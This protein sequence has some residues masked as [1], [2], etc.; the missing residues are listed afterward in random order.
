MS[1]AGQFHITYFKIAFVWNL[2]FIF[3]QRIYF[4]LLIPRVVGMYLISG[5]AFFI[6]F[7]R[8]PERW[9]VGKVDYFGHSHNWWHFFVLAALYYWHNTGKFYGK[10]II[11]HFIRFLYIM[12]CAYYII[13]I[14]LTN[15]NIYS[16]FVAMKFAVYMID[17]GCLVDRSKCYAQ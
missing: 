11:L 13:S 8:I 7:Y 10:K 3:E 16:N 5:T 9:L 14:T 15:L 4:Q 6:Y 17:N 1:Y 2:L 12:Q